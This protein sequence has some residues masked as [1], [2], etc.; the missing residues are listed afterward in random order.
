MKRPGLLFAIV[1]W[2]AFAIAVAPAPALVVAPETGAPLTEEEALATALARPDVQAR[3][4]ADAGRAQAG[5]DRARTWSNPSLA[6]SRERVDDAPGVPTERSLV[7]SQQFDLSGRRG[8]D[9]DAARLGIDAARLGIASAQADGK[10]ELSRRFH[11]AALAAARV[12][13]QAAQREEFA[14]LAEAAARRREAGDLSGLEARR[15]ELRLAEAEVEQARRLGEQDRARAGLAMLVGEAQAARP[16][17]PAPV[18]AALD[19][20]ADGGGDAAA[21]PVAQS[22]VARR[23]AIEAQAR[24][25]RRWS[26]PLT[27][28]AG[29]KRTEVAG[30]RDDAAILELSVPLPLFDRRR[31]DAAAAA[32][33]ADLARAEAAQVER[34]ARASRAA[35]GSE[36]RRLLAEVQRLQAQRLPAAERMAASARRAYAEGELGVV[37]LLD[38][39][40]ARAALVDAA[41][42]LEHRARLALIELERLSPAP[43][44]PME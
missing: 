27:V 31:A 14:R 17:A 16:L 9:I 38:A 6:F 5:L 40:D 25:A 35:A 13:A 11:E 10:A 18:P 19:E 4:D 33:D 44:V 8:L 39:L 26:L 1:F 3:W 21:A 22:A 32:A 24:A 29:I 36:A 37:E 28:G 20:P 30:V 15:I 34:D 12:R 2:P 42:E 7:L 23:D 43:S 41:L